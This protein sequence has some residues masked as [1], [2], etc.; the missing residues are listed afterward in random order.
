MPRWA[1]RRSTSRA[2]I[3]LG[4]RSRAAARHHP[5]AAVERDRS[6]VRRDD[7]ERLAQRREPVADARRVRDGARDVER[8]RAHRAEARRTG[9][10]E[11]RR[12]EE[13]RRTARVGEVEHD[14]VELLGRL[15]HECEA[16]ADGELEPRVVEC[17][18]VHARKVLA[19]DVDHGEIDLAE[20]HRPDRRVLEQ[21]L[22]G[23]AIA[24]ADDQR[25]FRRGVRDAAA[26]APASRDRRTRRARTS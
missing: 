6:E 22:R 12:V 18:L 16:V 3:L 15:T 7:R 26:C 8:H 19:G 20:L 10:V 23:A 4:S 13:R 25:A 5:H 24:S 1:R 21:L 9:A 14:Q 2:V 17:A 11:L